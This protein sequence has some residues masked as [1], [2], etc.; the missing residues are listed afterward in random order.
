[1]LP[2]EYPPGHWSL[3][4]LEVCTADLNTSSPRRKK[5]AALLALLLVPL[6]P[7][8]MLVFKPAVKMALLLLL[9]NKSDGNC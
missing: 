7:T 8:P 9:A 4:E 1:M 5:S 6:L 3:P 2:V